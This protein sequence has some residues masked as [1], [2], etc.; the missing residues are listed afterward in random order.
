[1]NYVSSGSAR[2]RIPYDAMP[3][4]YEV[5][6][7][8]PGTYTVIADRRAPL[9]VCRAGAW[10]PVFT[11]PGTRFYFRLPEGVSGA[12]IHFETD[13]LLY[14]PDGTPRNGGAP[15]NGWRDLPAG[16]PGL[17]SF[18]LAAPGKVEGT[19][20]PP[21]YAMGDPAFYFEPETAVH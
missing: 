9:I 20:F 7:A 4:A 2:V 3:G 10:R 18:E 6:L 12:R 16:L 11:R 14:G 19:E 15:V 13:A 21:F 5:K 1:V 17:W 8:R